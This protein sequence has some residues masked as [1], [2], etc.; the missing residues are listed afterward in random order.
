MQRKH[1]TLKF[2]GYM[3]P[4]SHF[5]KHLCTVLTSAD[6]CGLRAHSLSSWLP[7]APSVTNSGLGI[8]GFR[9]KDV[10]VEWLRVWYSR[11]R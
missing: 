6:R 3:V 11:A 8:S 2:Q 1:A 4:G 7:K 9:L 5:H 10:E